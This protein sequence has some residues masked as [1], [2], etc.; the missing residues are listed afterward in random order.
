ME[1]EEIRA[2]SRASKRL[3]WREIGAACNEV[4]APKIIRETFKYNQSTRHN[5]RKCLTVYY[6]CFSHVSCESMRKYEHRFLENDYVIY[7]SG[8]HSL[9]AIHDISMVHSGV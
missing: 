3:H 9:L 2:K 5:G 6:R 1:I 4:E 8:H 7:E